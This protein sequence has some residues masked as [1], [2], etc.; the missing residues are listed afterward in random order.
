MSKNSKGDNVGKG[1]AGSHASRHVR[2]GSHHCGQ[3][4]EGCL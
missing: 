4:E 1:K 2:G 3:D